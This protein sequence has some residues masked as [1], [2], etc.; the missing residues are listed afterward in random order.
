MFVSSQ[1]SPNQNFFRLKV[2]T[3]RD[4]LVSFKLCKL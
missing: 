4:K 1:N 2:K 3:K